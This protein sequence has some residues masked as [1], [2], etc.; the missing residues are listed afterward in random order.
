MVQHALQRDPVGPAPLQLTA[1]R[2]L[3]GAN[4]DEDLVPD[5]VAQQ[6]ADRPLPLELLEDE[7]HHALRLLVGVEGETAA[8]RLDVAD[9]GV[10]V[11]F[12]P[13][14]LV[15]QALVHAVAQEVDFRFAHRPFVACLINHKLYLSQA[16]WSEWASIAAR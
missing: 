13:A 16:P 6:C 8:R 7:P 11:D 3:V 12:A 14:G 9:G 1:L 5:Q 15:E 2:P 4:G 10:V